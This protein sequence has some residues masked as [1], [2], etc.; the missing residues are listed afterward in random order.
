MLRHRIWEQ[1]T[2]AGL[3]LLNTGLHEGSQY[4]GCS[5]VLGMTDL[6]ECFA[7]VSLNPN[8]HSGVFY[9]H[10]HIAAYGYTSV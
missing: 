6:H 1:L 5:T 4:I 9:V 2:L 7:Q 3:I 10:V 8:S